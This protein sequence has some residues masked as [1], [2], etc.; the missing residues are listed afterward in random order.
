MELNIQTAELALREAAE[1]NPGAWAEHSRYVAEACK[2]IALHCKDLSSEQAYIFGLLHDIGRYAGVS[3]ERHLID[4]YR[5]CMERGW[6]KAAQICIS[7]AFMIQDI[8][9]SIG[10]FD[11]SDEDY[12]FMKE[13]VA[14]AVYDDY[15]RLVQLCDALAM[16]SG[17]CLLEKRFVD[18]TMRYGVHPAT[19][20]R[21]KKILEIKERFEDQI[22]CSIYA[23]LPAL[24][25]TVFVKGDIVYY[26]SSDFLETADS[27]TLKQIARTRELTRKYYFP[28]YGDTEK[29]TSIFRELLGG[30]GE[31]VAIDTPFHCDYGKNIFWGNDVIVNM[32]CTFVDNKT[33]RIGDRVLI[34]SNVQIYTSTHPVLPQERFVPDWRERQTTFFRTY[35]RPIEIESNVWIG[36]GC[37][38]LPGV[39]IGKNSVIGA[40][41]V[42]TRPIPPNCAAVGNPCRVIR[43][44]DTDRER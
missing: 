10:E 22:G 27:D 42:V 43:Y 25:K 33:I 8:A 11:V 21:W 29:R 28:D 16:P 4:G 41:S 13:F 44:F 7:H 3:S 26:E 20:D 9:T 12:L 39:T 1:S 5:Y 24:W 15:D 31:N 19:I 37:I 18:V 30:I 40:G 36:G 38:L 34:A 32:N 2:N 17:F 6:G 14:N 35:A 23:L